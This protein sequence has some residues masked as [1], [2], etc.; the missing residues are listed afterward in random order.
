MSVLEDCMREDLNL[1]AE[2]RIAVLNPIK[3]IIDNY[4]ETDSEDCF[5]PNR[6]LISDLGKRVLPL[7][8]ELWLERIIWKRRAKVISAC[9]P[10]I[11]YTCVMVMSSNARVRIT[12]TKVSCWQCTAII[13]PTP[14]RV[15]RVLTA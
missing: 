14:N 2:R 9:S 6:P 12:M 13:F 11:K 15:R 3:L 5:A 8:R 1:A 7:S 10:A 4:P